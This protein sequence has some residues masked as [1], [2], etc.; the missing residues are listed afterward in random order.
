M[1]FGKSKHSLKTVPHKSVRTMNTRDLILPFHEW[2]SRRGLRINISRQQ[3]Y[4]SACVGKY[5]GVAFKVIE[6]N[7]LGDGIHTRFNDSQ[8]FAVLDIFWKLLDTY[9]MRQTYSYIMSTFRRVS[10]FNGVTIPGGYLTE[11][12][13]PLPI[14]YIKRAIST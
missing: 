2:S 4:P 6:P 3:S 1:I 8:D 9:N 13:Q 11:Q 12:Y 14:S 5:T 7:L 10:L